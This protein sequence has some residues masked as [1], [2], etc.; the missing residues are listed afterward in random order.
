MKTFVLTCLALDKG[1]RMRQFKTEHFQHVEF[2][3]GR[4]KFDLADEYNILE[5]EFD[6]GNGPTT[7]DS[8][9]FAVAY[10][11][12]E[13]WKKVATSDGLCFVLEDDARPVLDVEYGALD[14][15]K[16]REKHPY[17]SMLTLW[18]KGIYT[19]KSYNDIYDEL[20]PSFSNSGLVGYV[21]EAHIAKILLQYFPTIDCPVDHF[22]FRLKEL[23]LY[24]VLVPTYNMIEHKGMQ[25]LRAIPD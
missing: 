16:H 15:I 22:V 13:V 19:Q 1:K 24:K 18:K 2:V 25:S 10:G 20:I 5:N 17:Y 4:S 23:S 14:F 12:Y 3:I 8:G 6:F 7:W 11:H 21:L 9:A